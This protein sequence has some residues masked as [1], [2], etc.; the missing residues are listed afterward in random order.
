MNEYE[1]KRRVYSS[2]TNENTPAQMTI[3]TVLLL[4]AVRALELYRS[5]KTL[6]I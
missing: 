4:T 1:K 6:Y 3:N 2:S 5:N